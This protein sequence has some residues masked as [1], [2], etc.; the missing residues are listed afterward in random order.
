MSP[1]APGIEYSCLIC[2]TLNAFGT[3]KIAFAS[4]SFNLFIVSFVFPLPVGATTKDF[5]PCK[6]LIIVVNSK[7]ELSPMYLSIS[8]VLFAW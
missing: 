6:A 2:S 8:I 5:S 3:I 1:Q 7:V 4:A